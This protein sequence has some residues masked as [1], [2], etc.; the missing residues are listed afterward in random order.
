MNVNS[1]PNEQ[2]MHLKIKNIGHIASNLRQ[3]ALML[4]QSVE[5]AELTA[6]IAARHVIARSGLHL[7]RTSRRRWTTRFRASLR[8]RSSICWYCLLIVRRI[9]CF[10]T[11][12]AATANN[13]FQVFFYWC[14]RSVFLQWVDRFGVSGRRELLLFADRF[15]WAALVLFNMIKKLI[16]EKIKKHRKIYRENGFITFRK[17]I[18]LWSLIEIFKLFL[19]KVFNPFFSLSI[20]STYSAA[21]GK[22]A[23]RWQ[24][25]WILSR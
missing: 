6:L 2:K 17:D 15:F 21:F 19:Y 23:N 7:V 13:R 9:T 14:W 5:L 22:K 12:F 8:R 3:A 24:R 4:P 11:L 25:K 10:N 16:I 18:L 1:L 20:S